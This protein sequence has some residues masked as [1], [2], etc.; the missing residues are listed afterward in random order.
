[1]LMEAPLSWNSPLLLHLHLLGWLA[2]LCHC[3][4]WTT[5]GSLT[6]PWSQFIAFVQTMSEFAPVSC[7]GM[8]LAVARADGSWLGTFQGAAAEVAV[9]NIWPHESFCSLPCSSSIWSTTPDL[10]TQHKKKKDKENRK[11]QLLA[12]NC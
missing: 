5:P 10:H 11:K 4:C 9:A 12:C 7:R 3:L 1:V 8:T 2:T 6:C